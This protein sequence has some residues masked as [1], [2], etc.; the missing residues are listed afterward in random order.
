MKT[1]WPRAFARAMRVFSAPLFFCMVQKVHVGGKW[2]R[3]GIQVGGGVRLR[4]K[5]EQ[6][7]SGGANGLR[8]CGGEKHCKRKVK[9]GKSFVG[10]AGECGIVW[11]FWE[12]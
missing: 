7:W 4:E 3:R 9:G 2:R 10:Y 6:G 12:T 1:R 11:A 5:T 8:C